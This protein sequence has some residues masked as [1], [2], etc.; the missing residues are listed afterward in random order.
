MTIGLGELLDNL[1]NYFEENGIYTNYE[2]Q[3]LSNEQL[4]ETYNEY[5]DT[6]Y[7]EDD[8]EH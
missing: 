3:D 8:I 1:Y 7:T 4:I 5:L 2:L 6:N